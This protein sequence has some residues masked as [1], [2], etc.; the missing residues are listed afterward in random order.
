MEQGFRMNDF[1]AGLYRCRKVLLV[2]PKHAVFPDR[3]IFTN[4]PIQEHAYVKLANVDAIG[5]APLM[6]VI[7][8]ECYLKVPLSDTW[9]RR[10]I[11]RWLVLALYLKLSGWGLIIG[12]LLVPWL[13]ALGQD[14]VMASVMMGLMFGS[15]LL[16]VGYYIPHLE[17]T[18]DVNCIPR[19]GFLKSG[20]LAIAG[21]SDEFLAELPVAKA[22]WYHGVFGMESIQLPKEVRKERLAK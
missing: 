20:L 3:C 21:V 5:V 16:L 11:G 22:A 8:D 15:V 2:N 7:K 18:V 13:I 4:E 1:T 10:K 6:A 14:Q 12:G 17:D 19:V 9:R